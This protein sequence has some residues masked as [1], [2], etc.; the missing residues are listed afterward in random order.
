MREWNLVFHWRIWRTIRQ[1]SIARN[2]GCQCSYC[3]LMAE[4][5]V[6]LRAAWPN[7]CCTHHP[8]YVFLLQASWTLQVALA[9]FFLARCTPTSDC[10][11][12]DLNVHAVLKLSSQLRT[13]RWSWRSH[14]VQKC[15]A[16]N[17]GVR[18][19]TERFKETKLHKA[20]WHETTWKTNTTCFHVNDNSG[21]NAMHIFSRTVCLGEEFT[22]PGLNVCQS[23]PCKQ[24]SECRRGMHW[25]LQRQ[26][27]VA[28]EDTVLYVAQTTPS[29]CTSP[30]YTYTM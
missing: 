22:C 28:N 4:R 11:I 8:C 20:V 18:N 30:G 10:I 23:L 26:G 29:D 1:K 19:W 3:C 15:Y 27:N 14:G 21:D 7:L 6:E 9:H 13:L 25:P 12:C 17:D 5:D 24:L 16:V 2:Y